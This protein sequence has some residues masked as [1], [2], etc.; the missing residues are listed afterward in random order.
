MQA[1]WKTLNTQNSPLTINL[2][3]GKE[4]NDHWR[5]LLD[6]HNHEAETGHLLA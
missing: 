6:G 5:R 1:E 3:E 4:L 2:W